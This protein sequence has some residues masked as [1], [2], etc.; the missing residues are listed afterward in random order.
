M[1]HISSKNSHYEQQLHYQSTLTFSNMEQES[2]LASAVERASRSSFVSCLVQHQQPHLN[3]HYSFLIQ[4]Y[5]IITPVVAPPPLT[6]CFPQPQQLLSWPAGNTTFVRLYQPPL[7]Q[8]FH[9]GY[10]PNTLNQEQPAAMS[11]AYTPRISECTSDS[12]LPL[13]IQDVLTSTSNNTES[14]MSREKSFKQRNAKARYRSFIL[15]SKIQELK[16]Q[17]VT[18][19]LSQEEQKFLDKFEKKRHGK[20]N[21]SKKRNQERN[22]PRL[23]NMRKG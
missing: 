11:S 3:A 1:K 5:A 8:Y 17:K 10:H 19:T 13:P 20:N 18:R 6:Y 21:R 4:P 9:Q 14:E 15:R 16:Q 23:Q 22:K 7:S 12:P 2:N